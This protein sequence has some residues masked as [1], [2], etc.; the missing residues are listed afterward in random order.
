M[1][2]ARQ[3]LWRQGK[4]IKTGEEK[5]YSPQLTYPSF[6]KNQKGLYLKYKVGIVTA[7]VTYYC[8]V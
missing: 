7:Y 4:K 2:E 1:T 6:E 3:L 8:P 5:V